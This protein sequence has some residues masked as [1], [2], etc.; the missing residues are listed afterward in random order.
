MNWKTGDIVQLNSGGPKMTVLN[1]GDFG[2]GS[3]VEVVCA[4]MSSDSKLLEH[5]FPPEALK[6]ASKNVE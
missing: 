4:W 2:F 6:T 5:T 3:G 1:V